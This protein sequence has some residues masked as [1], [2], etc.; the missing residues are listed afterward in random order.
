MTSL[1]QATRLYLGNRNGDAPTPTEIAMRALHQIKPAGPSMAET[2]L[3]AATDA[4]DDM[5]AAACRR[6][7]G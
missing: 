5:V 7:L 6:V 2:V 1:Y 3:E 4:G